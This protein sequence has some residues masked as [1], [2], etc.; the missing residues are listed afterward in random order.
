M[1]ASVTEAEARYRIESAEGGR[2]IDRVA[3]DALPEISRSRIQALIADGR[4]VPEAGGEPI[5]DAAYRVRPGQA[6]VLTVPPAAPAK[7]EAQDLPLAVLYEDAALIV[8][9]KP[10]GLVI[11]PAPGN[12]DR[13]LVNALLAH[14]G[15]SLLGVGGVRRPGIVHRLD[16]DTSGVL[17]AA[18]T[19][20]AHAGLADQFAR[21]SVER[22]Y[23]AFV[24]G[25]PRAAEGMVEGAIG[26]ATTDRKKMAVVSR[27]GK[28]AL[29]RYR[30]Q[31]RYGDP[32][33]PAAAKVECR[34][35]TGRT[36][37]IRVH[38]AHIGHP[39]IGDPLYGRRVRRGLAERVPILATFPRQALHAGVLG[40]DHPVS[41]QRLRFESALPED[42][43]ILQRTLENL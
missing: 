14:C 34:L 37:Q 39:L 13:T 38:M 5:R 19:E 24:L 21:H 18:K 9:D 28:K 8:I 12:P 16:K 10:A 17:V 36:H 15:D 32:S 26:R 11:H 29:T 35:E 23:V 20:A 43:R 31:C 41:G 25:A 7:P 40:F 33:E 22:A 3:A 4:L 30:V 2:R 42:L 27:G 1:P 6:F